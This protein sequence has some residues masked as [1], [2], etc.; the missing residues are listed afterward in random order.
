ML[1][2]LYQTPFSGGVSPSYFINNII[3]MV[4]LRA[5]FEGMGFSAVERHLQSGNVVFSGQR[6]DVVAG[7]VV[8]LPAAGAWPGL[9]YR[10][11]SR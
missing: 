9:D 8:W 2:P 10:A 3:K 7:C 6:G 5:S 11:A 1:P 4:D